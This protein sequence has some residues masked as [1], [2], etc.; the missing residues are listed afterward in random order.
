MATINGTTNN[1]TLI[2]TADVD[3]IYGLAGHD[4]MLGGSGNDFLFGDAGTDSV[5]GEAGNDVVKGGSGI[6]F[7]YGGEGDDSI[8][9]DPTK[10]SIETVKGYLAES[11]LHG[12][13]GTDTLNIFNNSTYGTGKSSS[14]C[15]NVYDS[16]EGDII[17]G[18]LYG[19]TIDV[20][21]FHGIE[22][23]S[24]KG[25]GGL[26]FSGAGDLH[27]IE[28]TGTSAADTF[29]SYYASDKMIGGGGNDSFFFGGGNDSVVSAAGDA[30]KFFFQY[31]DGGISTVTGFNRGDRIY[32]DDVFMPNPNAQIVESD[33][34]TTFTLS[35]DA[36]GLEADTQFVVDK[37]GLILGV[38]YFLT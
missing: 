38:D 29:C 34:K 25:S 8:F 7:L 31:F 5:K 22:K 26:Q 30:D 13:D 12:E 1:D 3:H 27:G 15:I 10:S 36:Y 11:I 24:V 32:I 4:V 9:Y 35:G 37:G 17:F 28:I 16:G 14:T 21:N 19:D 23:I 2:G 33:G 20:G 6:G 18:N